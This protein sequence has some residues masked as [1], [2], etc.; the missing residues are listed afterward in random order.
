M[1]LVARPTEP[2]ITHVFSLYVFYRLQ[3]FFP[4]HPT[5][6]ATRVVQPST[7]GGEFDRRVAMTRLRARAVHPVSR[8]IIRPAGGKLGPRFQG[9][10][11][12]T[13]KLISPIVIERIRCSLQRAARFGQWDVADVWLLTVF[14]RGW[15]PGGWSVD[16]RQL[17]LAVVFFVYR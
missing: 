11:W 17:F 1:R 6:T 14:F 4:R 16:G 2:S 5:A 12:S 8:V 3:F 10:W 15:N 7:G 13:G 9:I